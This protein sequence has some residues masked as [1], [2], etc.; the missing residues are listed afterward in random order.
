VAGDRRAVT[1]R[2][3]NFA[4]AQ[5]GWFAC[6]LGA[7]HGR[8]WSAA[9]VAVLIVAI[10]LA[11]ARDRGSEWRL[12]VIVG[13]FGLLLDGTLKASGLVAYAGDTS[14]ASWLAPAWIVALWLLFA[15]TLNGSL[16]WLRGRTALAALLGAASGPLSYLSG[17]R[18]GAASFPRGLTAAVLALALLWAIAIPLLTRIAET[19]TDR[20]LGTPVS[21][22]PC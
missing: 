9:L 12:L 1:L 20:R 22:S 13:A 11:L 17:A 8:P 6:V 10:H 3:Y 21:D 15:T 2:V 4:A 7:A 16:S 18:L 19:V 14:A 5:V